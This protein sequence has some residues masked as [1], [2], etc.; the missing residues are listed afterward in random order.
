MIKKHIPNRGCK[1]GKFGKFGG[2][3]SRVWG[4]YVHSLKM[5]VVHTSR[6]PLRLNKDF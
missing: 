6:M 4:K 1:F 5:N 2:P 3:R